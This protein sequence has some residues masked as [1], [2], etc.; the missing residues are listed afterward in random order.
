MAAMLSLSENVVSARAHA[1]NLIVL[2]PSSQFYDECVCRTTPHG[3][4]RCIRARFSLMY[5]AWNISSF[6]C[7]HWIYGYGLLDGSVRMDVSVLDRSG[8][9]IPDALT[10]NCRLAGGYIISS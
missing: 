8:S 9:A 3:E 4:P 10:L 7:I 5:L 2:A 1:H 6:Q